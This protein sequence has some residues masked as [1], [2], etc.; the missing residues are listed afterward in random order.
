[1]VAMLHRIV[2]VLLFVVL[3]GCTHFMFQPL[4]LH[5]MTPDVLGVDYEDITINTPDNIRLHGWKLLAKDRAKGSVLFFHG[6]AENI[7]T[8]FANVH[9]LTEKGFNVYIFDY[10]GYGKSEGIPYLDGIVSD[11]EA[12]IGY[13]VK[14][15]PEKEKLNVIGHSLGGSLAIYAVANSRYKEHINLLVSVEAF[16]DYHEVTQN[17]LSTSWLT[18][19]F[20]WPFSFTVDNS[21]RPLDAVAKIS[22]IP[23]MIMHSKHDEVIPFYHAEELYAAAGEPKA[24][25]VINS[26]HSHVFNKQENRELLLNY[27]IN[28]K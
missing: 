10:R 4:P 19:L 21:Y 15:I 12:M 25:Q 13:T 16:S 8:H 23:I 6:N 14:Q 2:F 17:V 26:D 24:L 9:W 20:Q 1:M 5:F 27:L 28:N 11:V 7:S 18:W 22:P 3:A